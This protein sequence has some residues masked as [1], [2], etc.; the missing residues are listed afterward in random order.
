MAA[1]DAKQIRLKIET[2]QEV[3]GRWIA[4]IPDVPGAMAYG[5]TKEQAIAKASA[6]ALHALADRMEEQQTAK[7]SIKFAYA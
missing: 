6:L 7:E 1:L 4:E 2:E 5:S 3:D